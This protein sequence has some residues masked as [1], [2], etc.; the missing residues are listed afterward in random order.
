M[1]MDHLCGC[2]CY[3]GVMYL[4]H[5]SPL[6]QVCAL[7]VL[8]LVLVLVS[9]YRELAPRLLEPV[10]RSAGLGDTVYCSDG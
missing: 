10:E 3:L 5:S 2:C 1:A 6:S 7:L 8:V 9:T 4:V